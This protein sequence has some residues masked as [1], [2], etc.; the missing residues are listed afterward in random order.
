MKNNINF[1][2]NA[3]KRELLNINIRSLR[4]LHD[5]FGFDFCKPYSILKITGN[6]TVNQI[7]KAAESAG[8]VDSKIVV[9]TCTTG[10]D[11]Y[12]ERLKVVEIMGSDF[13]IKFRK[14]IPYFLDKKNR[15]L[16]DF[17]AKTQFNDIRKLENAIAFVVVQRVNDLKYKAESRNNSIDFSERYSVVDVRRCTDGKGA[18]WISS[19]EIIQ[20]DGDGKKRVYS[21]GNRP[22]TTENIIDKSGYIVNERRAELKRKADALRAERAKA[23]YNETDNTEKINELRTL[24]SAR[25]REII[26]MLTK[27][28]TATEINKAQNLL[29]YSGLYG[30]VSDYERFVENTKN[31]AYSSIEAS[32]KA[33]MRIRNKLDKMMEAA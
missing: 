32:D 24:I 14:R 15:P 20:R 11:Y 13:N 19:I 12:G 30:I 33:Y 23:A 25:K 4:V 9:L 31:K 29:G 2:T 28:K 1:D 26:A 17:Y 5:V 21:A 27:A 7:N 8:Y 16:D 10:H 3:N 22:D 18:H 6:Y